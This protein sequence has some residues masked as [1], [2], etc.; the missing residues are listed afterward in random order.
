MIENNTP[1]WKRLYIQSK[2][3]KDLAG[4]E[5]LA[6]NLW[7]SWNHDA[8]KLFKA[9]DEDKWDKLGHNPI[10]LLGTLSYDEYQ[11][12]LNDKVFMKDF[13]AVSKCFEEYMA[14]PKNK[15]ASIAYF[16]MEYGLHASFK[17]YS[18]GLGVLAGDFLK[19]ASDQNIDMV[20][21]GLLYRYGYFRQG[22]SL[23]GE[24]IAHYDPQRFTYLP[25]EPVRDQDGHWKKIEI[26]IPGRILTAKI[27][28]A[29]VGRI[30]LYLL[31]TD[32][33]ENS[34]EDR[35]ITHQLYGGDQENRLKQEI[36]LGIGGIRTL[37]TIG[38][39][40]DIYHLNEGHAA[41]IGLERLR[42]YAAV[43]LTH[44][45]SVELIRSSSLYTTHTPVPA[46]HDS[47]PEGM[48]WHYFNEFASAMSFSWEKFIGLGRVNPQDKGEVFS[49]SHLASKLSQEVNGVSKIHGQV[50]REMFHI[51]YPGFEAEELHIGHVT[52]S[53]HYYTWTAERWQNLYEKT[54]GQALHTNQSEVKLW[55]KI[56]KVADGDIMEIKK[57]QKRA[58]LETIKK[59]LEKNM[60]DRFESPKKIVETL[61]SF[62]ED[63][64]I[65]GFSR[66]FATYKRAALLFRNPERLAKIISKAKQPVQ[67][68]FAGKAHPADKA[69][70]ELIRQIYEISG[71]PEF[72][73][74]VIF[75][76]DYDMDITRMMVQGV[77]VW[78]NT[79]TRPLEASGT[80]GMKATMNGAINF[81]VLDGWWAEGYRPDAGWAL[82]EQRAYTNQDIQNELDAETIYG[83][84]ENEI[85][86][87][88]F[89]QDDKGISNQ[90]IARVKN[91]IAYVAPQFT[92]KRMMD[93]YHHTFYNKLHERSQLMRKNNNKKAKELAEWKAKV[94]A[95]WKDIEVAEMDVYNFA[96][97]PLPLGEEI[98]ANILLDI[99]D[100]EPE[101]ISVEML[102][103]ERKENKVKIIASYPMKKE[104]VK[105][106]EKA[107]A[108]NNG[109]DQE[110]SGQLIKYR[111]NYKITLSGVYEYGFR[112]Y[113]NHGL[114]SHR[115]DFSLV[116]WI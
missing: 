43:G 61:N 29:N 70:Q 89:D 72:L 78:L 111:C 46:G 107:L 14:K 32:I 102:I 27:W 112:V 79:P 41:F 9:I 75:L 30:S 7:W 51:M 13:H 63:A 6:K 108:G 42:Q 10:A 96:N 67:F 62:N 53:V 50:S 2:V 20:G 47:F 34:E 48:M 73:G 38:I 101:D 1:Q 31:D 92:M 66:R 100:L 83:I 40:P 86:P 103:A 77:D 85:I 98:K 16:C 80:S 23:L 84:L 36:L 56:H 88:Y 59:R 69:G 81:S 95:A 5:N 28:K 52:N 39:E 109:D 37:D 93:D 54:F 68:I 58:M 15:G 17:L 116:S 94:R 11:K 24:Q 87:E 25:L 71:R 106:E 55:K 74:K 49:M 45:E 3:P 99:G 64:L 91:A 65:F 105:Q 12:L 18:G 33:D 104:K 76:E 21:L 4:L 97:A 57:L 19:E 35:F 22:I 113:P 8:I 114:L 90:W 60:R 82:P 115:Q 44:N 26:E 110:Y